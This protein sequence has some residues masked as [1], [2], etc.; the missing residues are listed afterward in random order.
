MGDMPRITLT[1][2]ALAISLSGCSWKGHRRP[3]TPASPC[4]IGRIRPSIA[5][6]SRT[7]ASSCQPSGS[8]A[9]PAPSV[10]WP[11]TRKGSTRRNSTR[12]DGK[13]GTVG[14][15]LADTFTDALVVVH[16]GS[17]VLERYA[18]E[19]HRDTPHLLMS[20]SKSLV[21]SV[22]GCLV[23]RGA[24]DPA[25][26]VTAYVPELDVSGYSGARVR[27][28]LDM[29]SGVK[30][31]EDYTDL[32]SE[33]RLIEQA[34][35][36]RPVVAGLETGSMYEYL[37]T[38]VADREHGGPFSYRSCESDVLGWVCE[39]AAGERMSELLSELI[40]AP[41][42][43]EHDAEVTCDRLGAAIH[44]GGICATARDLARFGM[45]VLAG[46]ESAGGQ[47]VIPA[48]WL[49]DSWTVDPEILE[50]FA[51]S[52]SAPFM[53]GGWYRNQ[54]WFVP[55]PHG[56]VL[57]CLGIYGQMLYVNPATGTV[58]AKLSS[59]PVA[60]S[61]AMLHDTLG[62]FDTIGATLAGMP[63]DAPGESPHP[64]GPAG[65]A[66]GLSRNRSAGTAGG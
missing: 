57:L 30:F 35:G 31:S 9:A 43:A 42:G 17:V 38:L 7:C 18:G 44:D 22:V 59:W 51:Q 58:A 20:M 60:Q 16:D 56:P 2:A 48:E 61:A 23:Q 37:T 53:A 6:P 21:G 50:A 66:A 29:R 36:W 4:P 24:V 3:S 1:G 46:G 34:F 11:K 65:V 25:S 54:F 15:V 5:G 33:V 41:M 47:S 52:A 49:Q 39:R 62:A 32:S 10:P 64:T 8:P 26:L 27:D 63:I 28:L 40:W 19:T 55:R 13:V 12:T 45:L 14:Q